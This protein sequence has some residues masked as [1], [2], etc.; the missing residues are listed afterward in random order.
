MIRVT[1]L[2]LACLLTAN[3]QIVFAASEKHV[4]MHWS[5][6][7]AFLGQ[8]DVRIVLPNGVF[9]QGRTVAV[10]PGELALLVTKS[11]DKQEA[12]PKG[13]RVIPRS[14]VTTISY[15]QLKGVGY[16]TALTLAGVFGG[17]GL[18]ALY[19]LANGDRTASGGERAACWLS[20]LDWAWVVTTRAKRRTA[21]RRS[22]KCSLT[23]MEEGNDSHFCPRRCRRRF[24]C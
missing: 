15:T 22:S 9:V 7:G 14:L 1:N 5:E 21:A 20:P 19:A 18:G 8:G 24:Q 6:P 16:R 10:R 12:Y 23:D 13:Q 4:E 17:V 2:V 11:S 3:S